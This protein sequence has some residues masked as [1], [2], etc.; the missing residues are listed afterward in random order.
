M[1]STFSMI[2]FLKTVLAVSTLI[3]SF[4]GQPLGAQTAKLPQRGF[5]TPQAAAE[6]L[7]QAAKVYDLPA[8]ENILGPGSED[9]IASEDPVMDKN[10]AVEF[11]AKAVQKKSVDVDPENFKRATLTVGTEDWPLPIP[12][13]LRKGKWYFDTKAGR[14]EILLRRIGANELDAI[15]V[16]H[17]FVEAQEQYAEDEHANSGVHQYAQRMIS[18]PG[19]HDGLYWEEDGK[20]AGPMSKAIAQAIEEG[21]STEKPSQTAFHGYFFKILKAQGPEAQLGELDFV[22]KGAMIGGFALVAVPAEYGVTGVKT[23]LVS[24]EGVVYQKDLGPNSRKIVEGM[25][26]Y[27]PDKTWQRTFDGW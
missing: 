8:L 10:R 24:H 4:A 7:I 1:K 20:P 13:V 21:Y 19:T 16:C 27:N 15:T 22:I 14:E 9:I 26:K 3:V 6:A 23:F 2:S 12:I 5:D 11:A 18:T 25:D 17:G